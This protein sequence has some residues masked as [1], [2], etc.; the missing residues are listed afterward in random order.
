MSAVLNHTAYNESEHEQNLRIRQELIDSAHYVEELTEQIHD[1]A[2]VIEGLK[3]DKGQL[4]QDK[5]K[6][7]L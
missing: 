4:L 2:D 7:L 6:L 3:K 1:F 5:V